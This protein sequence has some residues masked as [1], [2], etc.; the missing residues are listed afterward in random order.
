MNE[1]E[2]KKRLEGVGWDLVMALQKRL[3]WE[4]GRFK[5]DLQS[6]I[7]FHITPSLGLQI[8]MEDYGEY[9][10]FG[11]PNPTTPDEILDWVQKKIIPNL[12]R[13]PKSPK[14]ALRIA[15]SLAAH[16]SKW[17]TVPY[18]FIRTTMKEDLPGILKS[19]GLK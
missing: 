4:H 8:I 2:Y 17:G 13:K 14:V 15:T 3:T 5:G 12:K 19:N 1:D 9:I 11:T 6:S 16:I 10:E 7:E 18:S